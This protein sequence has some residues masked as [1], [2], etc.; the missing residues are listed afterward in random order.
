MS[1]ASDIHPEMSGARDIHPEMSGAAGRRLPDRGSAPRGL[2]R[3]VRLIPTLRA[4]R[5]ILSAQVY[6]S[7]LCSISHGS[8]GILIEGRE[9]VI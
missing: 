4:P 8:V 9:A 6:P 3:L 5:C 1:G 2:D 7:L